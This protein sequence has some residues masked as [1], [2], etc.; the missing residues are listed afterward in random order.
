MH[1]LKQC[2]EMRYISRRQNEVQ[3]LR[4]RTFRPL[5]NLFQ[6]YWQNNSSAV[7]SAKKCKPRCDGNEQQSH[8]FPHTRCKMHGGD[9]PRTHRNYIAGGAASLL[10]T[11]YPI[12]VS[13]RVLHSYCTVDK[14]QT[15]SLGMH[16][17]V[18]NSLFSFLFFPLQSLF[19]AW[20]QQLCLSKSIHK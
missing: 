8:L 5:S 20:K 11:E 3:P 10:I 1:Y 17:R 4:Q 19:S 15:C 7:H 9:S 12:A 16:S 6:P 18:N 2:N 13:R 14:R